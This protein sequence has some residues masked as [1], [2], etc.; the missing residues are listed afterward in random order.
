[1]NN[2][3]FY[4]SFIFALTVIL[5]VAC[6]TEYNDVGANIIN[7]DIHHTTT[8]Y[9]ANV[10]ATDIGTGAVQSNNLPIN[11]L[12]AYNNPVF[13]KTIA[14]FVSQVELESVNPSLY[15]PVIDSVYIYIPYYSTLESTNEEGE[16][17]Y[18]LDSIYGDLDSQFKLSVYE[19]NYFLRDTDPGSGDASV[20]QYYSDE[21]SLVEA[22]RGTTLLNNATDTSQNNE[23]KYSI[24]E[25][26]RKYS[27]N[28][29]A[30]TFA[31][32]MFL[33]LDKDFFQDKILNVGES[34]NL[35]NNNVF[36]EYFRGLYF[37]VEQIGDQSVI[38]MPRFNQG[39]ITIKYTDNK[40]DL[41]GEPLEETEKKTITLNLVGN[42]I[43]FFDNTY[44][45]TFTDAITNNDL[46]NGDERL[47]VKGGS[48]SIATLDILDDT[49]IA[50]L[51][52][53]RVL[54]NE[55]NLTFFIDQE[56]MNDVK[57]P[58][59][60]YLYD[61]TNKRPLYDYSI[62]GT[63]NR[64]FPK[65]GK[66][67]HGGIIE[68]DENDKG[69]GYKIR[70]TNHVS[71]IINKDST[72]IQLGLVVT[73]DI[74]TIT[75]AALKNYFTTGETEVKTVPVSSVTHP[76]GTVLYGSNNNVPQDKRLKLEIFYTKPN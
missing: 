20:Q 30:E 58:I 22:N 29:V 24:K 73:E 4:K 60:I 14:Q 6:D 13:G 69:L 15:N 42:T 40:V 34:G 35:L 54:I 1:M 41:N 2:R 74:N 50:T 47:Y 64:S 61:L 46:V 19:N 26:E 32:G 70:L 55:A 49:D 27:G 31:P 33:Y 72:N 75:N 17:V 11:L 18:A 71:N 5:F 57:E 76:F 43:N 25:I 66:F 12:G 62:D 51:Q 63:S 44:S 16:G 39:K 48:G 21:K 52:A 8:R 9:E 59:R 68:Y 23:F 3:L 65:L 7:D 28:N 45:S 37:Q 38:G 56:A 36:R 67:V 10:I 53:E